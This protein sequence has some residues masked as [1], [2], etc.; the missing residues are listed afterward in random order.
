MRTN[1]ERLAWRILLTAFAVFLLL[2][3]SV[4]YLIQWYIF[5]STVDLALDLTVSRGTVRIK[6]PNTEEPIAVTDR[7]DDLERDAVILTDPTSQA[8][9]TFSDPRS[10]EPIASLVIFRDSEL[11]LIQAQAPRFGLNN[12]PYAIQVSS[13]SGRY[14]VLILETARRPI[15]FELLSAQAFTRMTEHGHYI[16]DANGQKTTVTVREGQALVI[17]R[18][19]GQPVDLASQQRAVVAP[20]ESSPSVLEA[21][22]S[23]LTN[24]DFSL[25]YEIGWEF[26]NDREPPGSARNT[27][28]DG[29]SVVVIDRSQANWPDLS[30]GHGETGLVQFLDADVSGYGYLEIRATFY[31][32]EQSL[33]T[34]GVAGSECPMMINMIY[35]DADGARQVFIHGFY[36]SHDPSLGYPQACATCRSDHER[37]NLRSWYTYE[38]G[39]LMELWPAEQRPVRINQI[40][41][42]ASGH[43][44]KVYVSEVDI[45]VAD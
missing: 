20:P 1:P 14:E 44:Y 45:L 2:C 32:D 7:R 40:S 24:S 42:Y 15:N 16:I 9:L 18:N 3:G 26:Y 12:N 30:L 21:E 29:R 17:E 8:V 25:D 34:C 33:S 39:N 22:R 13:P 6:L 38:T 43:A 23:L 19:T 35:E 5:Q 11:S 10:G 36:A 4:L 28:F 27:V 37:I 41:F 31:V